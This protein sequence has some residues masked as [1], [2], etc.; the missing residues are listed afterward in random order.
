MNSLKK[1]ISERFKTSSKK[2][3]DKKYIKDCVSSFTK[4][5]STHYK[6][7]R[8][9]YKENKKDKNNKIVKL[10]YDVLGDRSLTEY[11][12]DY[13][14]DIEKNIKES[15]DMNELEKQK[16]VDMSEIDKGFQEAIGGE[17]NLIFRRFKDIYRKLAKVQN[18]LLKQYSKNNRA[19]A[20]DL[21]NNYKIA[22]NMVSGAYKSCQDTF[23]KVVEKHIIG[24]IDAIRTKELHDLA[25]L[26]VGGVN[27]KRY[28]KGG[29]KTSIDNKSYLVGMKVKYDGEPYTISNDGSQT[30][31]KRLLSV[32]HDQIDYM[33]S[34]K[35]KSKFITKDYIKTFQ[36]SFD[37]SVIVVKCCII[38]MEKFAEE[39]PKMV[40]K[41]AAL[42]KEDVKRDEYE[43]YMNER[44][45]QDE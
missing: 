22:T 39:L 7:I 18:D 13:Y 10:Y 14:K 2:A 36:K 20:K 25:K 43:S 32:N 19:V 33:L 3:K 29:L 30:D 11:F 15:I 24:D 16:D 26:I 38:G 12:E 35:K 27:S 5:D 21:V 31:P 45:N 40:K 6:E 44:N 41:C 4:S 34:E 9:Y 37:E 23:E 8:K 17:L 42:E 1:L 28:V